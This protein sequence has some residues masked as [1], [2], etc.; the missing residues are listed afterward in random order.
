MSSESFGYTSK[1]VSIYVPDSSV[2]AYKTAW[3]YY[4]T[5]IFALST[6]GG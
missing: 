1:T 2:N 5:R 4:K 3:T 6:Y